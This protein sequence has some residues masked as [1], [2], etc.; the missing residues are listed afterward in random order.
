MLIDWF[1][2]AAQALNFVI[3]VWLL[4][5]FLY[6]PI[7]HAIDA[8]EMRIAKE[9]A[10][11]GAKMAEAQHERDEFRRKNEEFDQQRAALLCQATEEAK[12][13]RQRL[14]DEARSAAAA[15]NSKRL[16]AL[17]N[18]EHTLRQAINRR[19]RQ[20]V[21]A[22]ARKALTDLAGESLEDRMVDVFVRRLRELNGEERGLLISALKRSLS[23]VIVR[24]TLDLPQAQRAA[25]EA[26]IEE[27]L[28]PGTPVRFETEPDMISGIELATNGHKVA[29]TIAD[30]LTSL[31]Q[32]VDELIKERNEPKA[33]VPPKRERTQPD[34]SSR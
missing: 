34:S 25:T 26:A 28:G 5:R 23:P 18:E 33:Q 2:V 16:E 31:E 29:W 27:I 13:E 6:Q 3:L 32:G 12:A 20:E 17:R 15:L 10:D 22:I 30:Y 7:L 19:T 4:K 8:R 11:A 21:F 24:T 9:L 1:T 14:L